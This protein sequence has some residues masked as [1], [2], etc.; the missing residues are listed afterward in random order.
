[1]LTFTFTEDRE[2]EDDEIDYAKEYIIWEEYI[3]HKF[4]DQLNLYLGYQFNWEKAEKLGFL[5]TESDFFSNSIYEVQVEFYQDKVNDWAVNTMNSNPKLT[6]EELNELWHTN[7]TQHKILQE[8]LQYYKHFDIEAFIEEL[9][10]FSGIEND[11]E[12]IKKEF[13]LKS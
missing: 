11:P 10:E 4:I 5:L 12:V 7:E 6:E 1:M 13:K 3:P 2:I 8:L 9:C